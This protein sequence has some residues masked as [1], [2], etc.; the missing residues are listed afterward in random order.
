MIKSVRCLRRIIFT[1]EEEEEEENEMKTGVWVIWIRRI[2][3]N[4]C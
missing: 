3:L 4:V 2:I 1:T